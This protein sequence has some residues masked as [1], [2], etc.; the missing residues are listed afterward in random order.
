MEENKRLKVIFMGTPD[1]AVPTLDALNNGGYDIVLVVT[2]PDRPRGRSG[3]PVA[4]PVKRWAIEHGVSVFQPERIREESAVSYIKNIPAD[5]GVVAAFGQILPKSILD[6]PRLG[7]INVHASLLPKYRGA[8]PIQWSILNGDEVTGVTIMQMGVGLDDGDI[9]RQRQLPIAADDT[10]GSLFEKLSYLGGNLLVSTIPD[11]DAG[12]IVP[13]KQNE[14]LATK[15]GMINKELGHLE[16]SRPA[17]ELERYIRGLTP[18]PGAFAYIDDKL[19]KL[20]SAYVTDEEAPKDAKF[21]QI[22]GAGTDSI[23]I[24][25]KEGILNVTEL[26][27]AGKKRMSAAD[28][29]RGH[30]SI[31]GKVL[32]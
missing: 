17:V 25:T 31:T 6:H 23:R 28:Y 11:L 12:K 19:L 24:C 15:V 22:L 2:Q 27:A 9:L 14:E 13:E 1:F 10:G 30:S 8:A 32:W 20:H 5:V 29:L 3:E 26:Q 21:G 16:F 18:W 7:C 4:S